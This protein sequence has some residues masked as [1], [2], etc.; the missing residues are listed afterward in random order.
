MGGGGAVTA[1]EQIW[2]LLPEASAAGGGCTGG[3][4]DHTPGFLQ[5]AAFLLICPC[6]L[7]S[8]SSALSP[9]SICPPTQQS[10]LETSRALGARGQGSTGVA[11]CCQSVRSQPRSSKA[12]SSLSFFPRPPPQALPCLLPAPSSFSLPA[13]VSPSQQLPSVPPHPESVG[14]LQQAPSIP[15]HNCVTVLGNFENVSFLY[16]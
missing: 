8:Q 15:S 11:F 1:G 7:S 13:S 5:P 9:W 2:H 16:V 4:R 12:S 14:L 6:V 3:F 10:L